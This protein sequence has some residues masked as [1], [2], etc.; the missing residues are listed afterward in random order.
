MELPT[1]LLA[2]RP[3]PDRR[4]SRRTLLGWSAAAT[5]A[6][7]AGVF[8][9]LTAPSEMPSGRVLFDDVFAGH[10]LGPNHWNPYICDNASNGRAVADPA[11]RGGGQLGDRP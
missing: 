6:A 4:L 9:A 3:A 1:S 10:S 7:A 8:T 2:H 5:F 11:E